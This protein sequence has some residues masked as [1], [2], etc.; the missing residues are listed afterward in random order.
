M[1]DDEHPG[2]VANMIRTFLKRDGES[3]ALVAVPLRDQKT[4][5]MAADFK[6]VMFKMGFSLVVKG[7]EVCRDDWEENEEQGVG[8]ACSWS[9]W[10]WTTL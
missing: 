4:T 2:L 1:Y 5:E 8:V 10:K 6:E 7:E 3:R 9:I